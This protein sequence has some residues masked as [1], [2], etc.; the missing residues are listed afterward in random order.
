MLRHMPKK[1]YLNLEKIKNYIKTEQTIPQIANIFNVSQSSIRNFFLKNNLKSNKIVYKHSEQTKKKIS[2]SRKKFLKEN[3]DKHPWRIHNKFKSAPCDKIKE[4][5]KYKNIN[6]I[7]EYQIPNLERNFSIDI[8]FP[9]K[10]VGIEINGNQHYNRDG[11]L[12]EYY[13][14]RHNII[15]LNGWE[16]IELH[17]SVAY[18][19]N[20]FEKILFGIILSVSSKTDF[21]YQN[22]LMPSKKENIKS[23]CKCG[24][25]KY[26]Y[27]NQCSN[28]VHFSQRKAIR[29]S[30]DELLVLTQKFPMTTIGKMFGVTDNAIRKWCKNYK[31]KW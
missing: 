9:D 3:P 7:P 2:E 20:D 4:W 10:M 13:Q 5:L 26:K 30:K 16:L 25:E 28:C 12:K 14:N 23:Y 31:I 11:T 1:I 8:A 27:S 24:L 6:F 19:I 21:D 29:P 22:Y 18:H 17:Y 15:C